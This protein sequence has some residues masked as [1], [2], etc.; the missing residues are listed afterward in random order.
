MVNRKLGKELVVKNFEVSKDVSDENEPD[1]QGYLSTY[2]NTDRDGDVIQKGAFDESLSRDSS[3]S[4][5]YQH[6]RSNV[7]G[8][9]DLNS[10]ENGL[11]FKAYL[12]KDLDI[13]KGLKSNLKMG[14]LKYMSIGMNVL[15]QNYSSDNPVV[16]YNPM[17]ITK[18]EVLEGSIVTIPANIEAEITSVKEFKAEA[19]KN[20]DKKQKEKELKEELI[21]E[22][23]KN[24]NI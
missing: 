2:G 19:K 7:V 22:F 21:K 10:D 1:F 23:N 5:L 16:E 12:N 9:I 13:Y 24:L 6:D 11:Y 14:A 15:E 20:Y 3:A 4:L 17:V 18:A 8:R